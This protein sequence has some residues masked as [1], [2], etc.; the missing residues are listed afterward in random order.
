MN[1]G[2]TATVVIAAAAGLYFL[3]RYVCAHRELEGQKF[4]M[5]IKRGMK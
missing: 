5:N 2:I 1:Y 3:W 4:Y